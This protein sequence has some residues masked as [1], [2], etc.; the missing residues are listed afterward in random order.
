MPSTGAFV[1][2][3]IRRLPEQDVLDCLDYALSSRRRHA[4]IDTADLPVAGV[5]VMRFEQRAAKEIALH[6]RRVPLD[7]RR[8]TY[9]F[10]CENP[11]YGALAIRDRYDFVVLNIG[12]VP[13][14][15]DFCGRMMATEGLW[16]DIGRVASASE[17]AAVQ[18]GF[19]DDPVRL[20]FA[21]VIA[22]ECFDFLVRH[23]LAH[24]AL[25]HCEF[26]A[27]NGQDSSMEDSDGRVRAGIDSI[28]AQTLELAADGHAAIWGV[29]KL[30]RIRERLG[31]LPSGI[32]EAYRSFHLTPNDS[33]LNYLL[34]MFFVFRLFDET[35]WDNASL[36][37]RSH[38]PA[39]IR[40][41]TACI[42]LAE[43]FKTSGDME[44]EGR[45]LR[46]MQEVWP[47]GEIM[48][49]EALGRIPD[50]LVLRRTMS[51]ESERHYDLLSARART[52]PQSLFGLC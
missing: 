46:A 19:P 30:P 2:W 52:L 3:E 38:P 5:L 32:D 23:E 50:H 7:R 12:I 41:H 29:E 8:P 4:R 45:L 31:R 24:L 35:A 17:A 49:A 10:F 18:S 27:Q 22:S 21:T 15:V 14:I 20:A 11:A 16:A 47:V 51:E 26:L 43:H 40:F 48:F 33:M 9:A 1:V 25:G 6:M 36:G 39:P 34:A 44:A 37:N 28:A 42:H 13:M